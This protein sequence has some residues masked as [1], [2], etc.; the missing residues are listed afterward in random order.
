MDASNVQLQLNS[1]I[2][3]VVNVNARET[4]APKDK[5]C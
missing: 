4:V 2:I 1:G 5:Y 3:K